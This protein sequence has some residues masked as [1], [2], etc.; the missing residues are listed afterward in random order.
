MLDTVGGYDGAL[1]QLFDQLEY[2]SGDE[3]LISTLS[4]ESSVFLVVFFRGPASRG[5]LKQLV[6]G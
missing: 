4:E 3:K 2:P 1:H 6:G 5:G